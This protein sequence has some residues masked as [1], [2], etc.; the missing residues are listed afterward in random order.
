MNETNV[1]S[2]DESE[3]ESSGYSVVNPYDIHIV[4]GDV[5]VYVVMNRDIDSRR[6]LYTLLL[7][8]VLEDMMNHEFAW[9]FDQP[10]DPVLLGLPDYFDVIDK[11]MDLTTV[12]KN[13]VHGLYE[14]A[15]EAAKD[16]VLV[17]E[18]A[19]LYNE[20][21]T[22]VHQ[23]AKGMKKCMENYPLIRSI[24]GIP[25]TE[26][27]IFG[28]ILRDL[29]KHKYAWVFDIIKMPMKLTTVKKNFDY[30]LY[31]TA[32]EAA[33]D[34]KL[35]FDHCML[36][37]QEYSSVYEMAMEMKQSMEKHPLVSVYGVKFF[38]N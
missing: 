24:Y 33:R 5:N 8:D 6:T 2:D 35:V 19:L 23:M 12:E 32:E 18:N 9:V 14:S 22:V 34:L 27:H 29:M 11:P 4:Y 31:E 20:E 16:L 17:F 38:E 28:D 1:V 30:G 37:D 36:Y 25:T 10:V 26:L 7:C 15:E 13:F 21:G 3:S